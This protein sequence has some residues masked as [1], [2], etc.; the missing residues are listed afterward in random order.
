[1]FSRDGKDFTRRFA[2][3]ARALEALPDE[4]VIDGEIIAYGADGGLRSTSCRTV[5]PPRPRFTSTPPTC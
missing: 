3:I 4:T 2:S 1:L 5:A